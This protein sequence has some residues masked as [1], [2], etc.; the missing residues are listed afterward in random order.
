LQAALGRRELPTG[1]STDISASVRTAVLYD[2]NVL[3]LPESVASEE[4]GVRGEVG[5]NLGGRFEL[6]GLRLDAGGFFRVG[7]HA[8]NRAALDAYDSLIGGASLG[9]RYAVGSVQLGLAASHS[10]VFLDLAGSH[11]M[12][13]T[14]GRLEARLPVRPVR[15]SAYVEG[16]YRDF[17]DTNA[18]VEETVNDRDGPRVVAGAE[19][20]WRSGILTLHAS[21]GYLAELAQGERQ[22]VRGAVGSVRTALRLKPVRISAGSTYEYRHYWRYRRGTRGV[23]PHKRRTDHRFTPR[24]RVTVPIIAPVS[25][26]AAYSFVLNDSRRAF[27]YT[28][29]V[30]QLGVMAS[31]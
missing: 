19:A 7:A 23:P 11:F 10:Q 15:V 16:A 28:R 9:A 13:T 27:A 29:H 26:V 22:E 1:T 20:S 18:A 14:G 24:V 31:W 5:G 8:T 17:V 21:G 2:S 4:A 6:G 3:V 25:A 12:Q 30:G